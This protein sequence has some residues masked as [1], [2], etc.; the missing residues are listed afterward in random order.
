MEALQMNHHNVIKRIDDNLVGIGTHPSF[1]IGQR[2]L[3]VQSPQGNVLWDCVSL[4]D[5]ATVAALRS[6]GGVSAIAISHPHF[7]TSMVSWSRAFDAPVY[8]HADDRQWVMQPDPAIVHWEGETRE[9]GE[10]LALIRCGGH[11]PGSAVLHWAAGANGKGALLSGDTLQVVPD[12]DYLS[13]MYSYPNLIP[14]PAKL[15]RQ[16]VQSVEPFSFDR[17]YGGWWDRVVSKDAKA[18]VKRS[19]DR[20]IAAMEG[21][22]YKS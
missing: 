14:L 16:I 19:A 9:I 2:A 6:L 17:I 5:E 13:F 8:I 10:G 3:L 1:A 21:D 4:L 7:Y 18:S 11:F 20:Y 15:V 22:P 12:R